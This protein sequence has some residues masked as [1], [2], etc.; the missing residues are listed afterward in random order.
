MTN[1]GQLFLLCFDG[2]IFG[3]GEGGREGHHIYVD[4][5]VFRGILVHA[6]L[7]K[8]TEDRE[9]LRTIS[10]FI[11]LFKL[12]FVDVRCEGFHGYVSHAVDNKIRFIV[13][14]THRIRN[15]LLLQL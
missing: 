6:W 13:S 12:H 10:H 7:T 5:L 2:A 14:L 15:Y 1:G 8:M 3:G 4:G 11:L 9:R